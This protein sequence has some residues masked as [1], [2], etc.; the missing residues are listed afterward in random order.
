ML[1]AGLALPLTPEKVKGPF[2]VT[3]PPTAVQTIAGHHIDTPAPAF[4]QTIEVALGVSTPAACAAPAET[5]SNKRVNSCA[6]MD[7][8]NLAVTR[9]LKKPIFSSDIWGIHGF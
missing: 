9:D 1:N 3:G 2:K 8:A 6:L 7:L 4:S 5:V